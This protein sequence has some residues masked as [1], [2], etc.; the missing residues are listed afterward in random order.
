MREARAL[1]EVFYDLRR[2]GVTLRS[3]EDDA[4]VTDEAF[5]GMAS[6]MANK[7]SE[8]LAAHV[9]RGKRSQFER[10]HRLGGP[11]PDGY[12]LVDQIE[13]GQVVRR[14]VFDPDRERVIRT[15]AALALDGLGDPAIARRLNRDGHPTR[16]G[17]PWTRDACRTRSPTRSTPAAW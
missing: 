4:Y 10:G 5:V 3:V 2:H 13:E 11:V 8:D 6:K 12:L 14:Y 17:K 16:R 7:Y 9:R 15:M 1:G